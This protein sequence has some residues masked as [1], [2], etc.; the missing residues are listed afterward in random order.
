A[1]SGRPAR[2][3][4]SSL[5]VLV[6]GRP[7]LGGLLL[8]VATRPR[9]FDAGVIAFWFFGHVG[10]FARFSTSSIGKLPP[11]S[12]WPP[13]HEPRSLCWQ[14]PRPEPCAALADSFVI[15]SPNA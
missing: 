6:A 8:G 10:S 12:Q 11:Q 13:P 15:G 9:P 2:R 1:G 14:T 5:F 3:E 7:R 4:T